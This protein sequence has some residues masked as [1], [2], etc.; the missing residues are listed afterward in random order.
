MRARILLINIYARLVFLNNINARTSKCQELKFCWALSLFGA[1]DD[2]ATELEKKKSP[3]ADETGISSTKSKQ[4]KGPLKKNDGVSSD[5]KGI[6][7]KK[8]DLKDPK[9][10]LKVPETSSNQPSSTN[11]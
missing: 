2:E 10:E 6:K 11:N 9:E 1:D 4:G 5:S 7:K 8:D 3:I